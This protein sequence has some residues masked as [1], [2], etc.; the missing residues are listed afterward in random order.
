[1]NQ[2]DKKDVTPLFVAS[3]RGYLAIV[4]ALISAG[5]NVNQAD[6]EDVTPLF[7]ASQKGHAEV[8]SALIEHG[9][10]K[11]ACMGGNG[12]SPLFVA[13]WA[14]EAAVVKVLLGHGADRDVATTSEHLKIPA[15]STALSVSELKGRVAV[16]DLLKPASEAEAT[17]ATTETA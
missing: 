14:G 3:A 4:Q 1:M 16:Q 7:I 12:W 17:E 8:V 5:A 15:G 13:S 9:A 6:N 2:A 11:E 10:D